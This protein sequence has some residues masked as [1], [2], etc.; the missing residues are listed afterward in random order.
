MNRTTVLLSALLVSGACVSAAC[1]GIVVVDGLADAASGPATSGGAT[2]SSSS[3]AGGG[4]P[5]TGA[6][7]GSSTGGGGCDAASHT[8]DIT[9]FNVS[10][11]EASD[12]A[13]VFIGN[14]CGNCW[15]PWTAINVADLKKYQAEAQVKAAGTPG[16]KCFC[17]ADV[18]SCVQGQ[19]VGS[20]Q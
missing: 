6:G 19:C 14:F 2:A 13:P 16:P 17:P 12:C 7:G 18:P 4:A 8:I 5:G 10:C 20:L 9:E 11:T 15:C 1:G 3:G